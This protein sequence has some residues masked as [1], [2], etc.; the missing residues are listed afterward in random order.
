MTKILAFAAAFVL[1]SSFA[2]AAKPAK[3]GAKAPKDHVTTLHEKFHA[4]D[5]NGDGV[6][7]A[8]ELHAYEAK[9]KALKDAHGKAQAAKDVEAEVKGLDAEFA[10]DDASHDGKLSEA[11]FDAA[12][13]DAV[14]P[15][16][17]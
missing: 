11:E 2:L 14:A 9:V 8:A 16:K 6:I 5:A 3:K 15:K 4:L 1:T 10:R 17:P 7:D 12:E 13:S